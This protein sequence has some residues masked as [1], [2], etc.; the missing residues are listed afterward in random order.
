MVVSN[1]FMANISEDE[2]IRD[3]TEVGLKDVSVTNFNGVILGFGIV[4]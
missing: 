2:V 3:L 4:S 1:P